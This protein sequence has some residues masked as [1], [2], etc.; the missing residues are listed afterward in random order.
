MW[1]AAAAARRDELRRRAYGREGGLTPEQAAELRDL[2]SQS[3][4]HGMAEARGPAPERDAEQAEVPNSPANQPNSPVNP[5]NP[6]NPPNSPA[7][8]PVTSP[9]DS[10]HSPAAPPRSGRWRRGVLIAAAV[11]VAIALG[12]GIGWALSP[13]AD[14]RPAMSAEQTETWTDLEADGEYDPGSVEYLGAT[15]GVSMWRAT[16]DGEKYECIVLTHGEQNSRQC[17]LPVDEAGFG[18]LSVSLDIEEEGRHITVWGAITTDVAGRR[19]G[20]AQVHDYEAMRDSWSEQFTGEELVEAETLVAGGFDGNSLSILGYDGDRS[21]WLTQ[22]A[23][24]CLAVVMDG[25]IQQACAQ[26]AVGDELEMRVGDSVYTVK[27]TENRGPALTIVRLVAESEVC[28]DT[29]DGVASACASIDDKTGQ[30]GE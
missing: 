20:I 12:I 1:D 29:Q 5:P 19:V 21:V 3:R 7:N 2:E 11:L 4:N 27:M 28:D 13:A 25:E 9:T 23:E 8:P 15:E 26:L 10:P 30:G 16:S 22:E 18:A 6:P 14:A 24:Q 17:L